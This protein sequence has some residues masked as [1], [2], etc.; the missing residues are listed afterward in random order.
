ME[1]YFC[2]DLG[3]ARVWRQ[4]RAKILGDLGL[5][6]LE[7]HT[8]KS[9][10]KENTLTRSKDTYDTIRCLSLESLDLF[11]GRSP[12]KGGKILV[13]VFEGFLSLRF[14]C[15]L[16]FGLLCRC[17]RVILFVGCSVC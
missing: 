16:N 15:D 5:D 13:W 2:F 10:Q 9:S 17:H 12:G 6:R 14:V 1:S 3:C 11:F 8:T 4:I 7:L